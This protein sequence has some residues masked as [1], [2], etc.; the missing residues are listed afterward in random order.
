[1]GLLSPGGVHS[2]DDHFVATVQLAAQRGAR[3]I[4]VHGFLDGRDTPPRSAEAS[5]I[6]MQELLDTL[7]GAEFRSISG[8]YYAMDR[9]KRWDRVQRAYR[10]IA[11]ADSEWHESTAVCALHKAY[12]RGENDEFVQPTVIADAPGVHD[13][14]TI[15]FINFRADRAREITMAFVSEPFEGFDRPRI[16]LADFVCMTEYMADLPVSVAF[17]PSTLPHLLSSE[18]AESGLRQLRIAETEK[19]AHVTF[20]FNGGEEES[21]PF[22]DRTLIPSPDVATYDL[23]PEMSAPL[24]TEK[25]VDA[26]LSGR[27][28]V[29]ICN[30]ANPDMV[31]HTGNLAAAIKAVE[32]VD[33]CLEATRTA[34]D[35]VGGELLLTAD[36]GNIELMVDPVSGQKHT[37]HTTNKVPLLFHGRS[38]KMKEG[39]SLR[40]IAPTM[41]FLLG[42]PKPAEMTG[43]PLLEIEGGTA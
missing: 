37:A 41:L 43:Q 32:A 34:I 15:I 31:G 23:Q 17:P 22:E 8:R 4:A 18:L 9:D 35:Q 3:S 5:I 39:G 26:I 7:P 16:K 25:L 42:L 10:A 24:L 14:D 38:A 13:G 12:E 29:I 36:H 33:R 20:F 11:L 21:Y 19:Y 1:M 2:H 28:D 40:D 6:R 27:Y 30:V